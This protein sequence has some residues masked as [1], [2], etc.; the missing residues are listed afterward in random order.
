MKNKI[1]V[2]IQGAYGAFHEQAAI[3]Y[4]KNNE[5]EIVPCDSFPDVIKSVENKTSD[6]GMFAIENTV[7]GSILPNYALIQD[8]ELEIIGEYYMRIVQNLMAPHGSSIHDLTEVYSHPMAIYQSRKFFRNYPNIRL[9]E[10]IDTA[11]SAKDAADANI[12]TRGA[13]AGEIA[14]ERYNLSILAKGIEDNKKNYTRFF[15]LKRRSK[16]KQTS[17][18]TNKASICFSL[19][20]ST[21]SLSGVLSIFAYYGINL[22]KIQ[23]HPVIGRPGKY[24]FHVD[25]VFTDYPRYRQCLQAIH[26]L[27]ENIQ[28]LGEYKEGYQSYNVIHTE[29]ENSEL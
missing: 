8:S 7:A 5:I 10:S 14:A 21:G 2:A 23:S 28:I 13:I 24:S 25:L 12:K 9:I 22:H 11:L 19:P 16:V 27:I 1:K 29:T 15:A 26:P 3:R 17:A 18:D 4:F 6:Y 20:H